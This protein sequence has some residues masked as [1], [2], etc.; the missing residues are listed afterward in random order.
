MT[1]T[2]TTRAL[3]IDSGE[4]LMCRHAGKSWFCLPGGKLEPGETIEAGLVR[5]LQEET[6]VT[7]QL[8]RL[9]YINQFIDAS[10]HRVEFFFEVTNGT[11]YRNLDPATA[12]HAFEVAEFTFGNPADS[13]YQLLPAW[14]R[15]GFAELQS[16]GEHFPTRS[17]VTD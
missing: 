7:P 4:L 9:L 3:I 13:K 14:L 5:E 2:I 16:A 1:I 10:T 6:G 15:A 17:V 8:G 11:A 12:T